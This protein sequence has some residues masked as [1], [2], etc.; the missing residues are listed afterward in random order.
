MNFKILYFNNLLPI[1]FIIFFLNDCFSQNNF[2]E[3]YLGKYSGTLKIENIKGLQEIPMEFHLL[4]TDSIHK[5]DYIIVYGEGEKKQTR[6]YSLIKKE[7]RSFAVDENN[8]IILLDSFFE[9]TLYSIF[10][11]NENL[12]TTFISFKEDSVIWEV[13][14]A[15]KNKQEVSYTKEDSTK[16][17]SYPI[18]SLQKA[19]LKKQ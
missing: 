17:I 5:F 15:P 6:N 11:V 2:P 10:E 9:N 8:G 18:T 7:D 4:A 12:L 14:F 3:A 19:I 1:I 13:T 16:V